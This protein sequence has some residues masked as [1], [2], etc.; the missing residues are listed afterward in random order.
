MVAFDSIFLIVP[1]VVLICCIFCK[2]MEDT[3]AENAHEDL[4]EVR[5]RMAGERA[6]QQRE[7]QQPLPPPQ[8]TPP[9]PE[10]PQ[11][12]KERIPKQFF[13]KHSRQAIVF[14]PFKT[15]PRQPM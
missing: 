2:L 8:A 1:I 5:R 11:D 7:P 12:R 15:F 14:G 6:Q 10:L 9:P 3:D 4:P 13:Q